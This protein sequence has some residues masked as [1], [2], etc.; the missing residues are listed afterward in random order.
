MIP[1]IVLAKSVADLFLLSCVPL[2]ETSLFRL[3]KS[4]DGWG[5]LGNTP[6][7]DGGVEAP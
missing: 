1:S 6:L 5:K 7:K 2:A 4:T 3:G